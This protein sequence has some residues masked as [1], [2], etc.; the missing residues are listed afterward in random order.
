MKRFK[1]I[2]YVIDKQYVHQEQITRRV[3]KLAEMNGARVTV[4]QVIETTPIEHL[5]EKF[6]KKLKEVYRLA[7]SQLEN[8]LSA[9]LSGVDWRDVPVRSKMLRGTGFIKIIQQV[10]DSDHDLVIKGAGK[11]IQ[12]QLSM[13]LFRKCPCPV[14]IIRPSAAQGKG[15]I[16]A[17]VDAT[18][19]HDEGRELNTKIIEI[20][21]SL[22][23]FEQAAVHY[24]H[25][26]RLENETMMRGPRLNISEEEIE[27]MKNDLS[28]SA[29][30]AI[31]S[32]LQN[33]H[34]E[35]EERCVHVL[36][37]RT[38]T[39]LENLNAGQPIDTLVMGTVGRSGVPGFLIGN[40]AEEIL[41][42]ARSTV[43]AVKP[44][45][46]KSPVAVEE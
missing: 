26:W 45:N 4:C 5:G 24:L 1:N 44:D 25:T 35:P 36:E 21:S 28:S 33:S 38:S 16:L 7:T 15:V 34:V 40:T 32:V 14:W 3:Q 17:A 29:R 18:M 13:R 22:G 31:Y 10:I 37:G 23:V 6:S 11:S 2:L 39:V 41:K 9:L 19:Q 20:A 46:F 30:S 12:D 8:E 43:L 42:D 27:E